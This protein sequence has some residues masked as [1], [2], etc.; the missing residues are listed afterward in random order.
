MIAIEVKGGGQAQ[1][2]RYI[3]SI[4]DSPGNNNAISY[5]STLYCRLYF[6]CGGSEIQTINRECGNAQ[7]RKAVNSSLY[8]RKPATSLY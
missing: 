7:F 1:E 8:G 4:R 2:G 5:E 3:H 6:G